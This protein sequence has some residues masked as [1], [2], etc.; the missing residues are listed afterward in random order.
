[1]NTSINTI[2]A[3]LKLSVFFL[4]ILFLTRIS[5]AQTGRRHA[6]P[7]KQI[8]TVIPNR[9]QRTPFKEGEVLRYSVRWTFIHVGSIE[10][11]QLPA[12]NSKDERRHVRLTSRSASGLPFI[13][14]QLKDQALLDPSDPRLIE[15]VSKQLHE[16]KLVKKYRYDVNTKKFSQRIKPY[17]GRSSYEE[18]VEIK[19]VFD[20]I[21]LVMFIRGLSGSGERLTVPTMVDFTVTESRV[22]CPKAIEYIDVPAFEDDVAAHRISVSSSWEHS[23]AGGLQG[24]FKLWCSTDPAAVLLRAEIELTIGSMVIELE[25][26]RRSGWKY[27]S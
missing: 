12:Q 4:L 22:H 21:G 10:L 3:I 23:A 15:I 6:S 8:S 19:R 14:V 24:N 9:Y 5:Y 27:G 1:M 25:S 16:P 17:N 26:F 18:R 2:T 20:G 7:S 11:R 13:D